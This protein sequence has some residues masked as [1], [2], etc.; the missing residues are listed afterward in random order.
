MTKYNQLLKEQRE[1][2]EYMIG[3]KYSF[4]SIG[5]II[6]KDRTTIS[7]E[8]KRNRYLKSYFY[9]AF[10]AKGINEA[11]KKCPKLQ[12]KPYVCNTC[13]SK[14]KCN[15]HKLYYNASIAQKHYEETLVTSRK[16]IDITPEIIDEIEHAI[17][18]LIKDK[19][20]S[21]NQV[22]SNHSDIL[23]FSKVTF[24]K[25]VNI[26]VFSLKNIDLPKKVIYKPRKKKD[27]L[28]EKQYKRKLSLLKGRTYNDYLN[29]VLKHPNMNIC[30]MDT[31]EGNKESIKVLL[32]I[33][34]KDTKFML[35]RLLDKKN[36]QSVNYQFD[37]FK[38]KLGIK[39]Y[40]KVF[41]IVLTDNGSEFFDP[42]HIEYDYETGV[43]KTNVFYCK[44]YSSWQKGTIEKNHKYIRDI[45]PKG[46]SFDDMT[47]EQIQKLEDTIN[48]I[49]RDSLDGKTPYELTLKKYPEL[50]KSLNCSYIAPD[51]VCLTKKAILG[52]NNEK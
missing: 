23:Y 40:S 21:V 30:E 2:I 11:I 12:E 9:D 15:K 29:F 22:Y 13:P 44:P 24:Y 52:V 38:K 26:G 4:T 3:K 46:T 47:T 42:L 10:D 18:P 1:T 5:K 25:Y 43:K 51:D 41:R 37:L 19:K 49:P 31:V 35:I 16:G 27:E 50:I 20:Q 36:V 7:K 34:I 39:L 33:I 45:F 17:V 48:N 6:N 28:E 14:N 32:T 8:I